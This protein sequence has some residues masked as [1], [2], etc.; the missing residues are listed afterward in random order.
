R[1]S[2]QI[3]Q[4]PADCPSDSTVTPTT[5]RATSL[6][7]PR[8]PLP[9]ASPPCRKH[10]PWSLCRQSR[11]GKALPTHPWISSWSIWPS[12]HHHREHLAFS[13]AF[14][15]RR[16]HQITIG[17]RRC[18]KIPRTL[19]RH[20]LNHRIIQAALKNRGK[21]SSQAR[22][23]LQRL[24]QSC[25]HGGRSSRR[26]STQS[27][28]HW[29]HEQIKSGHYRHRITGK[30]KKRDHSRTSPYVTEYQ[31]TPRLDQCTSEEELSSQSRKN[32]LHQVEL[33]HG[34][35]A[36]K[37]EQV[38]RIYAR[39]NEGGQLA[40]FIGRNRKLQGLAAC[41]Y[42]LD[43]ERI[44][45]AITD[46]SR[47]GGFRYIHQFVTSGEHRHARFAVHADVG[48]SCGC[49]QR[50][51][52][53]T[54]ACPW[55]QEYVSRLRLGPG[56]NHVFSGSHG[57]LNLHLITSSRRILHHHNGIRACG[58]RGPSHDLNRLS[59]PY[60]TGKSS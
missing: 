28:K 57:P 22:L 40:L 9:G 5:P 58:N 50:N 34:N 14:P 37:E 44:A 31:R 60:R 54:Q 3:W 16:H 53:W 7:M 56:S 4:L 35:S 17:S 12:A 8:L 25:P 13:N 33:S 52:C 23:S 36:R 41:L 48:L 21:K 26:R 55:T 19:P 27:I 43:A 59:R 51:L 24:L 20:D 38:R 30:P 45:V 47:R 46:L 15:I 2:L 49:R 18:Q 10:P 1:K 32:L 39:L 11:N 6:Q 42:H 29:P